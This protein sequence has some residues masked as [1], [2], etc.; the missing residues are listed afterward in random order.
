[1]LP[2]L[3]DRRAI[4]VNGKPL[5][6]VYQAKELPDPAS[7]V[8][9]W[10]EEARRGGLAGLH[11]VAVETG[12]DT[13]WDA[14]ESGFDAKVLFQPQFS[15]LF[16]SGAKIDLPG[17]ESLR[18]YDYQ[19][20]W[21][22]LAQPET[23]AYRR[24]STV[25]PS[26]DNAART[27]RNAVVVHNATPEAYRQWLAHTVSRAMNEPPEHRIV[28]VNAW[29]EWGEG[30]HLEPDLRHGRAY[31]E[32]TRDAV[33]DALAAHAKGPSG[34]GHRVKELSP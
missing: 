24:Y 15:M 7:T 13:G 8:A 2:A 21:P 14:T 3:S 22:V 5:F 29:N 18:V 20:A 30:C 1:L 9:I 28:F 6:M 16:N 31:L 26:W 10:R 32:A 19:K 17:Q 12:W 23:V 34:N 33:A 27:G 11:L 4:T 25:F